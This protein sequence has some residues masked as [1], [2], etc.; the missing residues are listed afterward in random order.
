MPGEVV[1]LDIRTLILSLALGNIVFGTILLLLQL[2]EEHSHRN[3]HWT[4]AKGL[5]FLG[6][7]LLYLRGDISELLS[8]TVGNTC[9]LCGFACEC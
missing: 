3:K 8:Y 2:R 7:L 6:W 9:L 4:A 5:Q 1:T